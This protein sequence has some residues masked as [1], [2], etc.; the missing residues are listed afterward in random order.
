MITYGQFHELF[1]YACQSRTFPEYMDRAKQLDF[2][3]EDI[4][5]TGILFSIWLFSVDHSSTKIRDFTGLSQKEFCSK[6]NLPKR[7]VSNWDTNKTY[8][9]DWALNMICYAV[10]SDVHSMEKAKVPEKMLTEDGPT[11]SEMENQ[12]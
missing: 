7:T 3:D 5:A 2:Y 12:R 1:F 8:P 6:Y 10:L 4:V 9:G 11:A